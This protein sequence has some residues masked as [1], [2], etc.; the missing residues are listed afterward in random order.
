MPSALGMVAVEME[1]MLQQDTRS[2]SQQT[3]QVTVNNKTVR[4]HLQLSLM[5]FANSGLQDR[6]LFAKL[7]H[8]LRLL[9]GL[10]VY[11]TQTGL[12]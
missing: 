6:S 11:G 5:L 7:F 3:N 4:Q 12:Q 1:H 8:Q 9:C 2:A 10:A